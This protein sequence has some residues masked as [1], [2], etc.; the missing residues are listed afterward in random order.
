MVYIS[1]DDNL[2]SSPTLLI[3]PPW[4]STDDMESMCNVES[5]GRPRR[6]LDVVPITEE[7]VADRGHW[8]IKVEFVL[9]V[10]RE[11]GGLGN[12]WRFPY[13]CY[14]NGGG[15]YF[16]IYIGL[17]N[18]S[19]IGLGL[20][21]QEIQANTFKILIYLRN[22]SVSL[23]SVTKQAVRQLSTLPEQMHEKSIVCIYSAYV[24]RILVCL[25]DPC[26]FYFYCWT[27]LLVSILA[28]EESSAGAWFAHC[29]KGV[30]FEGNSIFA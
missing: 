27:C 20:F 14:K 13:L 22:S 11:I 1:K 24:P 28:K 19:P 7:K 26:L 29:L 9:S 18:H 2:F 4:R 10:A 21:G 8:G 5:S 25:R 12:I 17:I 6:P 16:C 30:C 23:C 15:K 3:M